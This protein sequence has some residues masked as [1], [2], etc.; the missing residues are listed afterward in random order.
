LDQRPDFNSSL[1]KLSGA[2]LKGI[3]EPILLPGSNTN[4]A[5]EPQD[6]CVD[7]ANFAPIP[8]LVATLNNETLRTAG[9]ITVTS[10]EPSTFA[11]G[12]A[13][14][15][16]FG[17]AVTRGSIVPSPD[18]KSAKYYPPKF[19]FLGHDSIIVTSRDGERR[20]VLQVELA[21]PTPGGV[22]RE[23][24]GAPVPGKSGD[25]AGLHAGEEAQLV[26]TGSSPMT[27]TIVSG[28]GS[29][30]DPKLEAA[31]AAT[32]AKHAAA[33]DVQDQKLA[34]IRTSIHDTTC[35]GA[36]R[37]QA[38]E[39]AKT[40]ARARM[41]A[42]SEHAKAQQQLDRARSTYHAPATIA[43]DETVT[44]RGVD[45]EGH[46]AT[47]EVRLFAPPKPLNLKTQPP[48]LHSGHTF[49]LEVDGEIPIGNNVSAR[50][51]MKWQLVSGPGAIGASPDRAKREAEKNA[52]LSSL[53]PLTQRLVNAKPWEV[54]AARKAWL[55]HVTA[56]EKKYSPSFAALEEIESTYHAPAKLTA[57]AR[58]VLR[59]TAQDASGRTVDVA[60]DVHP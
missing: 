42:T 44:L 46:T 2:Q 26:G 6:A 13:G 55:D 16:A 50:V 41:N 18:G 19:A 23:V 57:K 27:W 35:K 11:I 22:R 36:C 28:P 15:N 43:K 20:Q 52:F 32:A 54:E 33:I 4:V 9:Y 12:S 40:A 48:Q 25:P 47:A 60:F 30:G 29:V 17:L 39:A 37:T 21:T 5:W 1:Q 3:A 58:V 38:V 51:P 31:H 59:G 14:Y 53:Q 34:T 45:K 49:K 7:M 56:N 10:S 8:L 24:P